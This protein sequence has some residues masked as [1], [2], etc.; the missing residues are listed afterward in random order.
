MCDICIENRFVSFVP[1]C[2]HPI[3]GVC[4]SNIL[5]R[6]NLDDACAICRAELSKVMKAYKFNFHRFDDLKPQEYL[7]A[8]QS[9]IFEG[10]LSLLQKI[11]NLGFDVRTVTLKDIIIILELAQIVT[12]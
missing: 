5:H 7:P 8:S 6:K 4:V 10:K 9:A 11:V 12:F 3:C 1:P 2:Q